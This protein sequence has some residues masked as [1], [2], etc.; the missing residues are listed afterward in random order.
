MLNLLSL[1]DRVVVVTGGGTGL[2]RAMALALAKAGADIVVAG[3]RVGPIEEV[4][5]LVTGLGRRGLA[6]QTDVTHSNEVAYLLKRTLCEFGKADVLIN[7]AG[8]VSGQGGVPIW[9]IS[10]DD[11]RS[12]LDANLTGAFYCARIFARHMVEMG[13]GKIINVSSGMGLRGGRDNYMY[14]CAKGG[15]IQLTR[16]LAVSLGRYGLTSNC[17][18]PGFFP[19]EGT[20]ASREV[21]PRPE[22][23]P[24]G[25]VGDPY[26]IGPI[27]VFLAS[28]TSDY[29][30]GEMFTIDGG[31]LAGGY[32]P[33]GYA[34]VLPLDL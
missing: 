4:S 5:T 30:N 16:S 22:F 23:V 34:P 1:D 29:M 13:Q 3:R 7:N 28:S 15:V 27:A 21:L 6:V 19:T 8:M 10:D 25:R 33:T 2:G 9:D 31:G 20:D 11:W 24:M 17:I 18:V 26:E 14:A 32:A 12:V